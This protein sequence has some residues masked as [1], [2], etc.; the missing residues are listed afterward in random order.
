MTEPLLALLHLCDS[1][2]PLGGFGYSDGLE[3]AVEIYVK[4]AG[5]FRVGKNRGPKQLPLFIFE[6]TGADEARTQRP[7]MVKWFV[8]GKQA[9][10]IVTYYQD[11][12]ARGTRSVRVCD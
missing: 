10:R 4:V 6:I 12:F 5:G 9:D 7:V 1:L 2:F 3:A 11:R 8:S